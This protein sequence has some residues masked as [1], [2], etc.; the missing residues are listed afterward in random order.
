MVVLSV[1]SEI[2]V[3]QKEKSLVSAV[4]LK[5]QRMQH[6]QLEK[7]KKTPK[8]WFSP[9]MH[10]SITWELWK[11]TDAWASPLAAYRSWEGEG[12]GGG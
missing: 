12:V 1:H 10:I 11:N 2:N 5:C 4:S 3:W 9:W 8:R 7:I 6:L